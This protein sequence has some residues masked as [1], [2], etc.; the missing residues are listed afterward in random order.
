MQQIRRLQRQPD[1]EVH[2][3]IYS[4]G[5]YATEPEDDNWYVQPLLVD[6]HPC[7]KGVL[8][9][10]SMNKLF[11]QHDFSFIAFHRIGWRDG[12]YHS[13]WCPFIPGQTNHMRGPADLWGSV[14]N[15]LSQV[16][17]ARDLAALAQIDYEK[18]AAIF[19]NRTEAE[20]LASS[21]SLSLRNMD[22]NVENI[23]DFYN[24]QLTD[25]MAAGK[26]QESRTSSSSDQTLFAHV[27]SF[28]MHLGSARDYLA[29][30]CGLKLGM[31]PQKIDS[32]ARLTEEIR[33]ENLNSDDILSLFQS[34]GCF[35]PKAKS[36]NKFEIA[37]WLK[38]ITELRNEF[39]HRRPYGSRFTERMGF[40]KIV[41][42]EIGLYRYVRPIVLK[43]REDDVQNVILHHYREM[44]ALCH[45]AA[46]KSGNDLSMLRL[47]D[48]DIV[49]IQMD[50][51]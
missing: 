4:G 37:G 22:I 42:N 5:M 7:A 46:L 32:F 3:R 17:T 15:N 13:S 25:Q 1:G 39:M 36:L 35:K 41:S 16:R 31:D 23:A 11:R 21:I 38:E 29:A 48:D 50:G 51:E 12:R 6:G 27:Q 47:T 2:L 14:A 10:A 43:D 9:T 44:T 30:F 24:E 19:D 28:F 8:P 26:L 34:R 45:E 49:S 20:R 40:A 33:K 18:V